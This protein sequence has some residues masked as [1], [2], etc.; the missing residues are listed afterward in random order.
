MTGAL[1]G[2]DDIFKPERYF[3]AEVAALQ[4][5]MKGSKFT[6][7]SRV[8]YL[9]DMQAQH[10]KLQRQLAIHQDTLSEAIGEAAVIALQSA[11]GLPSTPKE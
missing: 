11:A 10:Q 8:R 3:A 7:A 9:Q 2:A 1:V 6:T 4:T 5:E